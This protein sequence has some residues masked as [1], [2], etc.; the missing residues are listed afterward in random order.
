MPPVMA[1][2]IVRTCISHALSRPVQHEHDA[3]LDGVD[4]DNSRQVGTQQLPAPQEQGAR[5]PLGE[6]SA[7]LQPFWLLLVV[8]LLLLGSLLLVLLLPG[9]ARAA[10]V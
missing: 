8:W 1:H 7:P 6:P 5:L 9:A 10:R 3:L 2:P 4:C